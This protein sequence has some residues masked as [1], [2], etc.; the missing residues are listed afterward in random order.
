MN[1][2]RFIEQEVERQG[3]DPR[4][5]AFN[6]RVVGMRRAYDYAQDSRLKTVDERDILVIARHIEPE[7]NRRGYRQTPAFIRDGWKPVVDWR[8]IPESMRAL[9]EE[10]RDLT[11][12]EFY[13][14][15]ELVHPFLDGNGRAGAIIYNWL[16]GTL[17]DPTAPDDVF[18]EG[19]E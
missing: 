5:H 12:I 8:S 7:R 4:T 14:E 15:F 16:S 10:G 19:E 6:A 3:F 18:K 9:A 11:P 1:I 17:D 2:D 13:T